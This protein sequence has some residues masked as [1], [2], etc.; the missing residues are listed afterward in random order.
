METVNY[1]AYSGTDFT[2]IIFPEERMKSSD[3][4]EIV[5]KNEKAHTFVNTENP[6][7]G[8]LPV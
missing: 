4:W 5:R 7:Y 2:E 8:Q 3:W 1:L 6:A